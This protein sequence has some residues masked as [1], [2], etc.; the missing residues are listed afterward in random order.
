QP[1]SE[2]VYIIVLLRSATLRTST[3]YCSAQIS[4]TPNQYTLLF[5]SDQPFSEPVHIIVLLRSATLRTSTHYCSAQISHTPNQYTLLFCSDQPHSEPVHIIVLLRSAIL[6]TSTHYCSAQISHTP[7]QYTLLF[8]AQ[9]SLLKEPV[10]IIVLLRSATLRTSTHYCS[11]SDRNGMICIHRL[12]LALT[13]RYTVDN[14]MRSAGEG[15]V[16]PSHTSWTG[17]SCVNRQPVTRNRGWL[18]TS[19]MNVAV[20]STSRPHYLFSSI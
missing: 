14:D 3:H 18:L 11:C 1:H 9:I 15:R 20:F 5:C 16:G 7:N 6:R 12:I 2:P 13:F 8:P 4:H 17:T 19:I 10:H